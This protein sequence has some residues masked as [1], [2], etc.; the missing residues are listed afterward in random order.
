MTIPLFE[1]GL[2]KNPI[3]IVKG[4]DRRL[5]FYKVQRFS[6]KYFALKDGLVL[7]LDDRYEYRYKRTSIYIYNFSNNKP[8][9]LSGMEEIDETL[10]REGESELWHPGDW[11]VAIE[12]MKK[13]GV[14]VSKIKPPTDL[15]KNMQPHTRRF[16][17]D[18]STDDERAKTVM[19]IRTHKQKTP[20]LRY[21]NELLGMGT[22]RGDFAIIQIAHKKLDIVPMY[23]HNDRAYTK[24]GVFAYTLDNVYY[25]K[26][27]AVA[28]F[29]LNKDEEDIAHPMP[30]RAEKMMVSMARKGR[31][32]LMDSY[33]KP[34]KNKVKKQ[35]GKGQ[36]LIV[37]PYE[38]ETIEPE[39]ETPEPETKPELEP[40]PVSAKEPEPSTEPE[41]DVAEEEPEIIEVPE[42]EPV[43]LEE[44]EEEEE[45]I[46]E[47]KMI[48]A[49]PP[50][51]TKGGN[52]IGI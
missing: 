5:H 21:S 52:L 44:P 18:Y 40:I 25:V 39:I 8:L 30:R 23:V 31:W 32:E 9:L 43:E 2:S 24:Y 26:K 36:V 17:Q 47:I 16:I 15:T 12:Q 14:D 4:G 7:E 50:P 42:P 3:A 13:D 35:K 10:K 34:H 11:M 20:I 1:I 46:P 19:M 49:T 37:A 6:D 41:Y 28:F 27:Q 29:V 45:P 48:E 33:H 51:K 38:V 22:N